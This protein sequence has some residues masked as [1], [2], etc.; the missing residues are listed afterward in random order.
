MTHHETTASRPPFPAFDAL[1]L[2]FL[3]NLVLQP[4]VEP[5]FGWHL[6]TGLDL[7]RNGW[8]LPA[9]DP[10]SHTMPDWPWV[11]HAWLTDGLLGLIYTGLGSV[12]P[13]GVILFFA[14]VTVSAFFV[15]AGLAQAGRTH[16]LLA[17][18]GALWVALPFL[19][20]RTQLV[21]L[22][23]LAV[24]LRWCSRY[25][26][27]GMAHL[28]VIPPLFLLWANLHGGFTAGL[29]V[30]A[31]IILASTTIR[32]LIS[33]W[34]SL[35]DRLD[36]PT[37]A[38]AHIG[39]L[40]LITGL[41]ALLT[42]VN[43][44]GWRLH[45]EIYSSLSD[46]F[47]LETLH[48]WQPVS[49]GSRAGA[50]YAGY[51]AALG[52]ALMFLYRR[53]EPVR[54]TILAVFVGLSL[55]HWRNVPFFLLIS[56]PLWAEMLAELT[57]WLSARFRTLVQ[58][59]KRWLL[60]ASL[61]VALGIGLLGPDHLKR[62]VQSGLAPAE[63]FRETEYPIEAVQWVQAHRDRVGTQLYNDYGFGG[64]L[65]WWLPNEKV[66]I[67]GRMP[68]WRVGDRR[69]FYDYIALTNWE[70]PALGVLQKYDVDWAIVELGNPLN[71]ALAS[72][73]D[74]QEIYKDTKVS[75]YVKRPK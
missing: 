56:V 38:W 47:M 19:G 61:A 65:L 28:W 36:E 54:W 52:V 73:G 41:A 59:Q 42:L 6:R 23:G 7:L 53:R 69:I 35:S 1:L 17:V 51:V 45:G 29:F 66:F 57:S 40:A 11:E 62:V 12:G 55:R 44:Y 68:A 75:I 14:G 24:V 63:F 4:L 10:Y 13:L 22:L 30:L 31:L 32:L 39:H 48:E 16:K 25:L 18:A 43:P 72:Q 33:R 67:D 64:F 27:G 74:W 70:P 60:A 49:P 58:H 8:R 46:R 15:M 37:P 26:A 9:T 71:R 5:D 3:L 21:T 34:P 20:A 50:H 2:V